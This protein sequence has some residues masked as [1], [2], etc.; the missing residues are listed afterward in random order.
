LGWD[1]RLERWQVGHRAVL[2]NH[3]FEWLT[4]A[5]RSGVI[6][7]VIA[8]VVALLMRRGEILVQTAAA[9]VVALLA[10]DVLKAA[11]PRSRPHLDPL[12]DVPRTH[13]FP[14]GHATTSFACA[15]VLAAAVPRLGIPLYLLAA[16]VAWSRVYVGVHWPSD[17]LAGAVLGTGVGI[18]VL[19]VL[20]RLEAARRRRLRAR[21]GG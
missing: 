18:L 9:D 17:V 13:S 1:H 11:I 21:R 4:R 8:F 7:L 10:S 12:I 14:S 3:A 6:W 2:L 16:A 19:R 15:T 5:G 20:P